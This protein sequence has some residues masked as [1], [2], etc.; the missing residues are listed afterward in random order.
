MEEPTMN[1]V[2]VARAWAAH[3]ELGR[4]QNARAH[5]LA[6]EQAIQFDLHTGAKLR[7][8]DERPFAYAIHHYA[9]A[10]IAEHKDFLDYL[11]R[12][13]DKGPARQKNADAIAA[14]RQVVKTV[15][16]DDMRGRLET[17]LEASSRCV[18]RCRRILHPELY[19]D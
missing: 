6:Q 5:H 10:V 14:W 9:A 15:N 7:R 2:L 17:A 18:P 16:Y 3:E 11:D 19:A 13:G 1:A 8:Q 4:W 12:Q